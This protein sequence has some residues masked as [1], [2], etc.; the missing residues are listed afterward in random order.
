VA[1]HDQAGVALSFDD[2][3]EADWF[4]ADHYFGP[5]YGWKVTFFVTYPNMMTEQDVAQLKSLATE[6]HEIGCHGLHHVSASV[7]LQ[8]HTVADYISQEVDPA[9]AILQARLG[10][11]TTSFAYP[12]GT[13]TPDL[14]AA[15][16]KQ[17]NLLRDTKDGQVIGAALFEVDKANNFLVYGHGIDQ[18][19]GVAPGSLR[20]ALQDAYD[21]NKI[22]M[23][24][25][26]RPVDGTPLGYQ[27]SYA[28]LEEICDFVKTHGMKFYRMNELAARSSAKQ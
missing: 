3:Y 12:H 6:G 16:P 17:F 4:A 18:I 9:M 2:D 28:T 5:K 15:M 10:I 25:G 1:L 13:S 11:V 21:N 22:L 23:L 24:Y 20:T 7:F 27:T 19:H 26:H 8:D 14:D